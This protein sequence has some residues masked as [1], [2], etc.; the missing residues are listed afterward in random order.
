[1]TLNQEPNF[2]GPA[3]Q[4]RYDAYGEV[5]RK[6]LVPFLMPALPISVVLERLSGLVGSFGSTF[7]VSFR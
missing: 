4:N 1:M 6:V 3:I 5:R 2:K 7:A